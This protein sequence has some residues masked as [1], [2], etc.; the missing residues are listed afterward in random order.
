MKILIINGPNLNVLG[1]RQPQFYGQVDFDHYLETLRAHY[2]KIEIGFYHS[3]REGDLIDMLHKSDD[4]YDGVVLNAG[5]YTHTSIALADAIQGIN[6][7]VVE[8]HIS[9]IYAREEFRHISYIAPYCKGVIAGFGL[10][11]YELA[12][13]SLLKSL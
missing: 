5:A 8:V 2:K 11:S 10:L 12:I 9:N 6:V 3:S 4:M 7:P 1:K 13:E